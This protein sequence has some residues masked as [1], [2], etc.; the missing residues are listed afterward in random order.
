MTVE[1]IGFIKDFL[2]PSDTTFI[3]AKLIRNETITCD[4]DELL[5]I[6]NEL[7]KGVFIE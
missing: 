6:A 5:E 7:N 3:K 4:A 2:N 1:R